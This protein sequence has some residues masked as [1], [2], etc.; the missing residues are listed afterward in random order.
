MLTKN[1][2]LAVIVGLLFAI[3]IFF[4][5]PYESSAEEFSVPSTANLMKT[6]SDPSIAQERKAREDF[7]HAVQV[8]RWNAAVEQNRINEWNA[9]VER[10]R[11][12]E[13]AARAAA[14]AEEAARA[15]R[16]EDAAAAASEP[17]EPEEDHSHS[18]DAPSGS[19]S[20][21]SGGR[22]GGDLPP[23]SV[24]ECE[25]GGDINAENPSSSA[26]GKW[27]IISGTWGNYMGYPTAAS[28]P[29]WVQ[30]QRAAEIYAGGSGRSQWQC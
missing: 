24:M 10:I 8:G 5:L 17:E 14:V 27:Q 7:F 11:A 6:R 16:A 25:S 4:S 29:E 15:Q 2:V 19:S 26:S 3:G 21:G 9:A 12:E 23:C 30:D 13:E 18:A 28:A 22:C 20:G 1:R